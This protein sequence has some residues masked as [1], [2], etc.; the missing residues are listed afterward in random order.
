MVAGA[1]A[2]MEGVS[3]ADRAAAANGIG[4]PFSMRE[5]DSPFNGQDLRRILDAPLPAPR[6]DPFGE[7]LIGTPKIEDNPLNFEASFGFFML[8]ENRVVTT[9]TV[10]TDNK[11]LS[12]HDSG[13]LQVAGINI[14]CRTINANR[15]RLNF[16]S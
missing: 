1:A 14:T 9:V 5:P 4:N 7:G 3:Q 12:F 6:Y 8:D 11:E 16:F 13:G 10:Q 15:R 2:T